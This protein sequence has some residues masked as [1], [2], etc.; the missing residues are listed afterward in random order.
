MMITPSSS[1]LELPPLSSAHSHKKVQGN[2][3]LHQEPAKEHELNGRVGKE[4]S[5]RFLNATAVY[6]PSAP[7]PSA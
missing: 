6:M 3:V 7:A 1:A 2:S 4:N 5:I